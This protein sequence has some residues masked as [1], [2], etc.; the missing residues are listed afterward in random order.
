[1]KHFVFLY[2]E[3]ELY[4]IF[5][6][7]EKKQFVKLI[8]KK[9]NYWVYTIL[10]LIVLYGSQYISSIYNYEDN[11][12]MKLLLLV[13]TLVLSFFVARVYYKNYYDITSKREMSYSDNS[14]KDLMNDAKNQSEKEWIVLITIIV[15]SIIVSLLFLYFGYIMAL[16][17]DF[18]LFF[19]VCTGVFM[20]PLKKRKIVSNHLKK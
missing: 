3:K 9:R 15:M 5:F 2:R 11:L 18:L 16:I 10:F 6:D 4:S 14:I 20:K 1:M 19:L 7:E 13:L 12:V 8:H 17:F